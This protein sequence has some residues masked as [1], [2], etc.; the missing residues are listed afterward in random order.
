MVTHKGIL[1]AFSLLQGARVANQP[2]N[3]DLEN[4]LVAWKHILNATAFTDEQLV[5]AV[6]RWLVQQPFWPTPADLI[7]LGQ[8]TLKA[9]PASP[10]ALWPRVCT[11]VGSLGRSCPDWREALP[12]RLKLEELEGLEAE[13]VVAAVEAVGY[14]TIADSP[15]DWVRGQLSKTF[16]T[17]YNAKVG[18]QPD[19]VLLF[20]TQ[21]Q[22]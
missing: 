1:T 2:P 5:A 11:W 12:R 18:Q 7:R 8:P 9:L 21:K 19:N 10:D 16:H 17:V 20:P 6:T 15:N 4:T 14:K 3:E 13:A 22:G